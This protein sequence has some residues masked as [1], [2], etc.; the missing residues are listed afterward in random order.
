MNTQDTLPVLGW[1]EWAGLP[2]LGIGAVLAKIDSGARSCALHVDWQRCEFDG[3]G[4][5]QVVFGLCPQ[6][7]GVAVEC[8]APVLDRR[9]VTDSGGRCT[10]RVFIRTTLRL[11]HWQREV[12][13]N[14]THRR[15]LRHPMLVGRTALAGAWLIDPSSKYAL[16]GAP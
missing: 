2:D 14:L 16:G 4:V 11:G 13:M 8:R 5:E 6:E 9:P 15:G 10:E 1:R 3:S 7:S 12:E